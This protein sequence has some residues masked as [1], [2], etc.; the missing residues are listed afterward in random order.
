M[1]AVMESRVMSKPKGR[2]KT[3]FREDGVAKI[4]KAVLAKA[5]MVATARNISLAEYLSDSLRPTVDRDFAR[6]MKR[7]EEDQKGGS[8]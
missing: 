3:S 4:E 6:E 8:N 2:P 7:L 1:L 5:K